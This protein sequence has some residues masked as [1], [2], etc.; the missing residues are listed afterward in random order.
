VA[1][2]WP[3]LWQ[4]IVATDNFPITDID[5]APAL[6]QWLITAIDVAHGRPL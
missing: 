2:Q 5:E 3:Q 6:V 4:R 1:S